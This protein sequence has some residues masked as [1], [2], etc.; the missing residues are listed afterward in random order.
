VCHEPNVAKAHL[1]STR[2]LNFPYRPDLMRLAVRVP[3]APTPVIVANYDYAA[4]LGYK[5]GASGAVSGST[6]I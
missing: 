5:A 3:Q 2:H 6:L 4:A 1:F